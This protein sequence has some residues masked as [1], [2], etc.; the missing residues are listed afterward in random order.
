M[1]GC[2]LGLSLLL[3]LLLPLL[4]RLLLC[5]EVEMQGVGQPCW[6]YWQLQLL[7]RCCHP[8]CCYSVS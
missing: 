4:L 8:H 1:S 7:L 2:A 5:A 3:P 6:Q